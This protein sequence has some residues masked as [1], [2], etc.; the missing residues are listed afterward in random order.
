M[1]MESLLD[2]KRWD[3]N[4]HPFWVWIPIRSRLQKSYRVRW[5]SLTFSLKSLRLEK[6]AIDTS[7]SRRRKGSRSKCIN[8]F[9]RRCKYPTLCDSPSPTRSRL[10]ANPDF[11]LPVG[12]NS[13]F[14][15]PREAGIEGGFFPAIWGTIVMTL[16]MS[17]AV[18]PFGVMAALYMKE[19]AKSVGY[20]A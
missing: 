20:L 3:L 17:V 12:R 8:S 5:V 16:I 1:N 10:L 7:R 19:Y 4:L 6:Q 18:M 9:R 11:T 13:Y 2:A 15:E 14:G